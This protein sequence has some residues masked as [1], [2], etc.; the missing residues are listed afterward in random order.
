M[1]TTYI[2]AQNERK[3]LYTDKVTATTQVACGD[4][5]NGVVFWVV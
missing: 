5:S 1:Q 4:T 2:P 3:A